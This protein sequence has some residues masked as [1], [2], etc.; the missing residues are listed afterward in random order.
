MDSKIILKAHNLQLWLSKVLAQVGYNSSLGKF[1]RLGAYYIDGFLM[2]NAWTQ[3]LLKRR[4]KIG[5]PFLGVD[6]AIIYNSYDDVK[7]LMET[8]PQWR[9]NDLGIIRILA[10]SYMLGNPLTLGM[11]GEE[12]GGARAVFAV[13][14]PEPTEK[15]EMLGNLVD[16]LLAE[17][18]VK[19]QLHIGE[20]L[21]GMVIKILHQ[22][23]FDLE[24]SEAQVAGS[25]GYIKTLFLA[26]L[27]EFLHKTVLKGVVKDAIEH[28]KRL[29]EFYQSSPRW[30]AY[31]DAGSQYG[32]N[33]HQVV[34]SIFDM[35]HIAG[36]AGT[37]ALMGSV[38]GMLCLDS[39]LKADVTAELDTLWDGQGTPDANALTNSVLMEKVILETARLYPPV[40]FTCQLAP[41]AGEVNIGATKCPF[42]KGTRLLTSIFT[43][44][45]DPQKYQNPDQFDI[46]RDNS[47]ILAWNAANHAR[48]CPGR[49][50]SIG[51][52]KMVCFYLLK[53]YQWDS[54]SEVKWDMEKVTAV[55][56]N[57]LILSGFRNK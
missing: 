28:R 35:I 56:P 9:Q 55:T 44:N 3:F 18:A 30:Q 17:A 10:S 37:S 12:H 42:Q 36:T 6:Q 27:P 13:A 24:L 25:R 53:K 21:P 29:I 38:I 11:N 51:I 4:D 54:H 41:E 52:I 22:L 33:A 45:R 16:L 47:D 50:L 2:L 57:D 1:L 14:I 19:G 31:L 26:S 7:R 5:D 48:A 32:L 34:N 39:S 15:A 8:E 49:S 20:D 23:I 43:A 46:N 40:R